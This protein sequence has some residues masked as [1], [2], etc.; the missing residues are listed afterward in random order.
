MSLLDDL[1]RAQA[2]SASA[3]HLFLLQYNPNQPSVH[4]FFEGQDDESFYV[5]LLHQHVP[6]GWRLRLY[7][8]GNKNQVYETHNLI[9]NKIT[10]NNP[11][12]FFV[13][14]DHSDLLPTPPPD[15][16]AIF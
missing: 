11:T 13:D 7:R 2:S 10:V 5:H 14:K 8:C 9:S 1:K 4:A 6:D 12:L 15:L 3:H 16:P